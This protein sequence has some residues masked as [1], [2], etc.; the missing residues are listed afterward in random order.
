MSNKTIAFIGAGNMTR[1]IISGLVNANYPAERIIASNPSTNK[2]ESLKSDF[3]INTTQDNHF[4]VENAHVVVLAVK[5]QLMED[6]CADLSKHCDLQDKL[7]VSIAAGINHQRLQQMLGGNYPLVRTM[8]NTPSMLRKGMTGLYAP[9]DVSAD[10]K[11][12]VQMIMQSVGETLWVEEEA[13]IDLVIAAAGSSPAYF[14]LFLEAMQNHAI[15]LGMDKNASRKLVQQAM[16]GAAEMVC[17]N[18]TLEIN[19]LRAQVTSKGGT[20]AKAIEH[21]QA[22]Q[23]EKIIAGAMDAAIL[24]AGQMA[25]QF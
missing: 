24:R 12:L 17:H 2:L 9:S 4:A 10:D 5:P 22:Q 25:K 7:F 21:F 23:L 8:P 20:T 15:E 11:N 18:P 19:E 16:L 13:D 1:S 14:F 6:V 3:A